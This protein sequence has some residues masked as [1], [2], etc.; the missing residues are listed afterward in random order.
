LPHQATEEQILADLTELPKCSIIITHFEYSHVVEHALQSVIDQDHGDFECIIV[1]DCSSD[2]HRRKLEDIVRKLGDS[3]VALISTAK[4]SGQTE[5]VFAALRH[6]TS[7]FIALLDPDDRYDRAFLRSMLSAHLNR[8]QI[9]AVASCDMGLYRLGGTLLSRVFSRFARDSEKNKQAQE[10]AENLA[11]Y[12]YSAYFPPWHA[13]WLWCSTSSLMF[14]RDALEIIRPNKALGYHQVDAYCAQGAHMFGGTLFVNRMLSY[15]GLHGSNLMHTPRLFSAYQQRHELGTHNIAPT[16]KRDAVQ[17]FL[18][19]G[20]YKLF[21]PGRLLKI[22]EAHLDEE[23]LAE[24]VEV[25]AQGAS[26]PENGRTR[27]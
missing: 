25:L 6:C 1:D 22:F 9:A 7:D 21:Q 24:F 10:H 18:A 5:A 16:A 3:R 12:G 27:Q 4:N 19:N 26:P 13:G 2:V 20:G 8:V 17:A 23:T 15:R 14:R 11:K